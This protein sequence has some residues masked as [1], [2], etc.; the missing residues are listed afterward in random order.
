MK[1]YTV[2]LVEDELGTQEELS[3]ILRLMCKEVYVA[4]DGLKAKALYE[5]HH[6]D[7]IITDI[8]LGKFSGLDLIRHIRKKDSHT[9]IAIISAHTN[10]NYLLL[11]TELH[12]LKYLVK[13][14]TKSKL[15]NLFDMFK[16]E[17][18]LE[19][20]ILNKQNFFYPK[21]SLT[22]I[23]NIEYKLSKKESRFLSLLHKKSMVTY[24]ELEDILELDE[25]SEH[26]I[27]QFIKKI[28]KKL[29]KKY[30]QNRQGSGYSLSKG[31]K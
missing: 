26:A 5:D 29:P 9:C 14:I 1:N 3:D 6:P 11:A 31:H 22:S 10:V 30:L 12:L 13:P 15:L 2:L 20:I 19:E 25:F 8:E 7:L 16:K 18:E 23:E 27:R 24:Y 21:R 28:R 4:S 17:H